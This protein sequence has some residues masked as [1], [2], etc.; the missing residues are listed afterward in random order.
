MPAAMPDGTSCFDPADPAAFTPAADRLFAQISA[1]IVGG[2]LQPGAKLSEP[3]LA[4]RFG[5]SRAPL[6]EAMRRLEERRL[7]TRIARQGARVAVLSPA[8]IAE[9]YLVREVLEG[10]AA[11]EAARLMSDGE[12][13]ELRALLDRHE[14]RVTSSNLY[15]QGAD[16]DDF[17]VRIIRASGNATLI[18][19]LLE[20]YYLLL[21]MLRG[22]R[23]EPG[24]PARRALGEHRRIADAL[25]DRDA[26]LAELLMRRHIAAAHAR[27]A[28]GRVPGL[29]KEKD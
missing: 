14:A 28:A 2:D 6:R 16:D 15:L 18:A 29:A 23:R 26:E 4:A 17:H 24:S 19:L 7:V 3:D 22:Q 11:R 13:G 10:A 21:R 27:L 9:I 20:E 5:T 25:C 1:M 8:R 12:L